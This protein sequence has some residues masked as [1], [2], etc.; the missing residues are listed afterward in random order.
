MP[1]VKQPPRQGPKQKVQRAS[2]HQQ[3]YDGDVASNTAPSSASSRPSSSRPHTAKASDSTINT[4]DPA[5]RSHRA[6]QE[7]ALRR[8]WI[9]RH[10]TSQIASEDVEEA[11][12]SLT[13]EQAILDAVRIGCDAAVKKDIPEGWSGL[14]VVLRRIKEKFVGRNYEGIF[15]KEGQEAEPSLDGLSIDDTLPSQ[16]VAYAA[17]YTAGRSLCYWDLLTG[18]PQIRDMLSEAIWGESSTPLNVFALGAGPAAEVVGM[19]AACSS[20]DHEQEDGVSSAEKKLAT[21]GGINIH[22]QDIADYGDIVQ[23]LT[24]TSRDMFFLPQSLFN[25][26]FSRGDVLT[27]DTARQKDLA[28]RIGSADI[29]TALFL[30]NELLGSSKK[31]FV[32]LVGTLV[33]KMKPGSFLLVVDSAGSFSEVEL[34]SKG[35]RKSGVDAEEEDEEEDLDPTRSNRD[36]SGARAGQRTYMV[37]NLLDQIRAF[38]IVAK[39]DSRWYRV[40]T[41]QQQPG[42][43]YPA[44]LHNMRHFVRLYRRR[45]DA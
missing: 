28:A 33:A 11:L 42:L 13:M 16:L 12:A 15:G 14:G 41:P 17:G 34:G 31:E 40:P 25:V 4:Q 21:G 22:V 1:Q 8:S 18:I 38:D 39:T 30:L 35:G 44:K 23:S 32:R 36:S 5:S 45:A 6:Q 7:Q 27:A 29:V 19:A 24:K 2:N 9:N 43:S 37:Y 10:R 20:V 26:T 3:H